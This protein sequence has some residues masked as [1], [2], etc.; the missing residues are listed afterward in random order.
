VSIFAVLE[1]CTRFSQRMK[2]RAGFL[3]LDRFLLEKIIDFL[4]QVSP[5]LFVSVSDYRHDSMDG[6]DDDD[7]K[8]SVFSFPKGI[9]Q[10]KPAYLYT[11]TKSVSSGSDRHY[12][13]GNH[14]FDSWQHY[15]FYLDPSS[16][17]KQERVFRR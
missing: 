7:N 5:A 15:S 2:A 8:N 10:G 14:S 3:L 17:D 12:S 6:D 11:T 9:G 16:I 13:H 4:P 1:S